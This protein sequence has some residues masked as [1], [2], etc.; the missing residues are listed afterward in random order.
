MFSRNLFLS[1]L[2]STRSGSKQPYVGCEAVQ[3]PI[4]RSFEGRFVVE[5]TCGRSTVRFYFKDH[6][7]AS[8]FA[9]QWGGVTTVSWSGRVQGGKICTSSTRCLWRF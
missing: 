5:S 6:H 9:V 7:G 3:R 8:D 1:Q 4:Y 2:A